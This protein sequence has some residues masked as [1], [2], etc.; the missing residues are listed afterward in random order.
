M[1][2]IRLR[3]GS[4]VVA[5]P[6]APSDKGLLVEAFERL[7]PESRYRRFLSPAIDLAQVRIAPSKPSTSAASCTSAPPSSSAITSATQTDITYA[8]RRNGG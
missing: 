5:R 6:I 2:A 4:A 7:S 8:R 3:D 1:E